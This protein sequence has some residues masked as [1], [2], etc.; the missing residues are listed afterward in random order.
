MVNQNDAQRQ[1]P[2]H[3][4]LN[5]RLPL[6]ERVVSV[7]QPPQREYCTKVSKARLSAVRLGVECLPLLMWKR[8]N[9]A[10]LLTGML[11]SP[12]SAW[13]QRLESNG[14]DSSCK[15]VTALGCGSCHH[16]V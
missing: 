9:C 13:M 14:P 4:E 1:V 16:G 11:N 6:H 5:L 2:G 7:S 15:R 3:I 12:L 10:S 8:L